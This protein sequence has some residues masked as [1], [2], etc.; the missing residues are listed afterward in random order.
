MHDSLCIG[1]ATVLSDNWVGTS[2]IPARGLYPHQWS[3]DTAFISYGH[4]VVNAS[5][6]RVELEALFEGQWSNGLLP[7]IV[8]NPAVAEGSYFPGPDYWR[9]STESDGLAPAEPQTSGIVNPPVHAGAVLN[10]LRRDPSPET[11]AF[12]QRIVPKLE[13][14]LNY[15]TTE[16]DPD[17][18]GLVYV[19]HP[20]ENGLDNAPVW[21]AVL[22]AMPPIQ[23][24][25]NLSLALG[26]VPIGCTIPPYVR[27][28][29]KPG[30]KTPHLTPRPL[31]RIGCTRQHISSRPAP[32]QVST[33]MIVQATSRTTAFSHCSH[34]LATTATRRHR[35]P[36]PPLA[37]PFWW[38]MSSSTPWS[39][40][41]RT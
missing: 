39:L 32:T 4:A 8:F 19:R 7:H 35:S 22:D 28:D 1:A 33:H 2:T 16:R 38:R 18:N 20:W 23:Q 13:K 6:A 40:R 34:A 15:L 37:A 29:L 25:H 21:D 14:F 24:C 36:P 17:G 5:R 26:D 3:W 9:S 10:L 30:V 27:A 31:A 12:T 11:I 41:R